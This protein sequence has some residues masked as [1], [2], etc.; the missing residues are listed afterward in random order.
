M[1]IVNAMPWLTTA[2]AA[3]RLGV[4]PPTIYAYVSRGLLR[5]HRDPSDRQSRF[6]PAEVEQLAVR[7]RPR[8]ASRSRALDLQIDTGITRIADHTVRYRGLD[9]LTLART[10]AFEQVAT[11]LW[12]GELP[13][14][15][16]TWRGRTLDVVP[17][18]SQTRLDDTLRLTLAHDAVGAARHRDQATVVDQ[19]SRLIG[20]LVDSLPVAGDGRCP[21]L[22]LPDGTAVRGTIAGRLWARLTPR[23]ATPPLMAALNAALVLLADHEMA[24]STLAARV[25]AS[26]RAG[27]HDV[28]TAGLGTLNGPLHGGESRR[29]RR[30]FDLA[31][32]TSV[33]HA[34]D[35]M[36]D[37]YGRLAGF[38]QVV[39]PR[40]DPRARLL[41]EMLRDAGPH[42]A[43]ELADGFIAE[44]DRRGLPRPNVDLALAVLG[45]AAGM[46]DDAGSAIF[47]PARI[48]GWL[49]HAMEE[50]EEPPV[51]FRPR[52]VYIGP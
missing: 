46:P 3:H 28:V 16:T 25:A 10:S 24:A 37:R 6:D 5:S 12:T 40:G 23:R 19:G 35:Q 26:T 8:E 50:Y 52:A 27:V 21:R 41:L 43:I 4:K 34:T 1:I 31:T 29:V 11:L 45:A 32:A 7:G 47:L 44:S 42:P 15:A 30:M 13:D 49:A 22:V 17:P 14:A 51:R 39:Y 36:L 9:A 18:G 2:Q 33:R 38:G 20:T 48:A